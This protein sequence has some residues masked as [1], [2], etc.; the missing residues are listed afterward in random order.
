[1]TPAMV[2]ERYKLHHVSRRQLGAAMLNRS[3]EHRR[4]GVPSLVGNQNTVTHR[5]L[6]SV[7]IIREVEKRAVYTVQWRQRNVKLSRG[8]IST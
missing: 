1:M 8:T 4:D 2:T 3:I 6:S 5:H 7:S